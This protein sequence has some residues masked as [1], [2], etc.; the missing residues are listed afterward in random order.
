MRWTALLPGLLVV[1]SLLAPARAIAENTY[2]KSA[3][4][5]V[6]TTASALPAVGDSSVTYRVTTATNGSDCDSV[7]SGSAMADCRW[8]GSGYEPI[9]LAGGGDNL[10]SHIA[11]QILQM[12]AYAITTSSTV[13]GRDLSVDGAKLD[14]IAAGA[15]VGLG[16][17]PSAC[18]G[19]QYVTDQNQSGVLTCSTP[20]GLAANLAAVANGTSLTI[21]SSTGTS[22]SIPA[23][24]TSAWGAMTDEDKTKLDGITA[25]AIADVV[26]DLTPQLGGDLDVQRF[27]ITNLD[28]LGGAWFYAK[29]VTEVNDAIARLPKNYGA[30][31][32][33]GATI[34]LA[35]GLFSGFNDVKIGAPDSG[36]DSHSGVVIRGCGPGGLVAFDGSGAGGSTTLRA[37]TATPM[38]SLY[39]CASCRV[40]NLVM[41]GADVATIGIDWG[42]TGGGFPTTQ[43]TMQDLHIINIDGPGVRVGYNENAIGTLTR[44][45][46]TATA[47][48]T[49]HGLSANERVTIVGA[50]DANFNGT[51][52]TTYVDA[53]TFTY[54]VANT[55]ATSAT[56][57]KFVASQSPKTQVDT[58][59]IKNSL[60]RRVESCYQQLHSQSIGWTME[61]V[62]CQPSATA[63][64]V[65]I[66]LQMGEL[67]YED[68]YFS[69][70]AN[71]QVFV[72]RGPLASR[73]TIRNNQTEW[74][75]TTGGT[76]VDDDDT[77][78]YDSATVWAN[79]IID[80]NAIVYSGAMN[81][82]SVKR[83]GAYTVTNN[84]LFNQGT[85]GACASSS[86]ASDTDSYPQDRLMLTQF[87][88]IDSC[89]VNARYPDTWKPTLAS[90]VI[91]QS[92]VLANDSAPTATG[93]CIP[94]SVWVD[95]NA[96]SGQRLNTCEL[97]VGVPT[98]V[99]QSG[100]GSSDNLGNH[101]AT[102]ALNM[103][104][105]A[106]TN[107]GGLQAAPAP[108]TTTVAS[109]F[110]VSAEDW[111]TWFV[112][113]GQKE[114]TWEDDPNNPHVDPI[115]KTKAYGEE[116]YFINLS[117]TEAW[118]E[119][120]TAIGGGDSDLIG[121]GIDVF[122][123]GGSQASGDE[124]Y[125]GL[126]IFVKDNWVDA[127]GTLGETIAAGAG[128]SEID[129]SDGTISTEESKMLGEGKIIVFGNGTLYS[130]TTPAPG[131]IDG[132]GAVTAGWSSVGGA[133]KG[134]WVLGSSPGIATTGYCLH[135]VAAAY[136]DVNGTVQK[137]WLPIV[138]VSG[139]T[140]TTEWLNQGFDAGVPYGYPAV[141][142]SNQIRIAACAKLGPPVFD[143]GDKIVDRMTITR[144]AGFPGASGAFTV[145]AYP[146]ITGMG[147]Q[148][149][150]ANNMGRMYPWT[151]VKV[152]NLSDGSAMGGQYQIGAAFDPHLLDGSGFIDGN[153]HAFE[154]G[155]RCDQGDCETGLLYRY[156]TPATSDEQAITIAVDETSW[157]TN[158]QTE[159][160]VRIL[161]ENN[162]HDL[163]VS[164]A[165]GWGQNGTPF[166]KTTTAAKTSGN[167]ANW[168]SSGRVV[169]A[170]APCGSG[171][172]GDNLRVEDGDNGGTFTAMADADFE[173]SGDVNFVRTAGTPDQIS[174]LVRSGAVAFSE[175]AGT[176]GD[177]QIAAG[178]VDLNSSEVEGT[179]PATLGGT[180]LVS[181]TAD[182]LLKAEGASAFTVTGISIADSTN[183]LTSP[184]A[185]DFAGAVAA[186]SF[187]ADPPT[188]TNVATLVFK[189]G[190][191][192]AGGT[193]KLTVSGP[194][195][196]FASDRA[197]TLQDDSTPF[198]NCVTPGSLADGDKGDITVSGS[199]ATWNVDADVIASAEIADDGVGIN[200]LD[201]VTGNTPTNG[202]CLTYSTDSGG[203]LKAVA[204]GTGSV[205]ISGTPVAAQVAY[206]TDAS[207][208]AGD[209]GFTYDSA[210]DI[211]TVGSVANPATTG[212][213][214]L[215]NA[216]AI[217][218][219]NDTNTA[220]VTISLDA[221]EVFQVT[222]GTLDAGDLSGTAA[223][224]V[225]AQESVADDAIGIDELDLVTGNTPTNGQCLSYSTDAGGS[226]KA[227][228]CGAGG[229]N[230]SNSGTPVA[231]QVAVWLDATTVLGDAGLTFNPTTNVLTAG[232][233]DSA[234][235]A[236]AGGYVTLTE[237]ADDGT[238]TW[239]LK[240]PDSGL[241]STTTCTLDA[242]G[243]IPA[244][245][246]AVLGAANLGTDSVSADELNATGVEAELE[247][248][249][250][251]T[252]LSDGD[253]ACAALNL[254]RRNAG[255]TAFECVAPSGGGNVSSA[256]T[257]VQFQLAI[258]DSSS[259]ILGDSGIT[260]NT[261]TDTITAATFSGALS[262]NATTATT[263]GAGD[264]AT[265]FFSSGTIEDVIIT[266]SAESDEIDDDVMPFDDADG[267]FTA[268]AIGPALEELNDSIN[269][270]APNGTGAKLHWSQ[271]LG[272]PAGFADGNDEG[273]GGGDAVQFDG[274]DAASPVNFTTNGQTEFILCTGAG[275]PAVGCAAAG[276]VV[277]LN[278]YGYTLTSNSLNTEECVF[279]TDGTGGGGFL[280]EGTGAADAN[281]QRHL[282]AAANGADTTDFI[283][284]ASS[285]V[286]D[287]LSAATAA[288][289]YIASAALNDLGEL[290]TQLGLTNAP[291]DDVV[292]VGDS[293]TAGSWKAL[294]DSD[295]AGQ[296]LVY[297]VTTNAF[298]AGTDDDVPEAADFSN[299]SAVAPISMNPTGTITT[300]M[301]TDRLLGRDTAATGV[302][303]EVAVGGGL[304]F[305]GAPG[306]QRSALT[307]D[308]TASAGSNATTVANVAAGATVSI[309]ETEVQLGATDR[310][311]GRDTAGAG[312]AEEIQ[313]TGGLEFSGAGAI[314]R[315]ALTGD[316]TAT[317]GSGTTVVANVPSGATVSVDETEVQL[318]ATDR[319]VGR[320]TAGA[321]GAEEIAVSGGLE[322]SGAGAI[323]RSALTGDVTASAGSNATA[324]AA[325]AVGI[326]ELDLIDGDTPVNGDCLTYDTG[327][328]GTIE[329]IT[330]PSGGS[331]TVADAA[332]DTTTWP[333]LALDQTG[334]LVAS[335]DAGLSYDASAN[336]L[337]AT[338]GVTAGAPSDPAD[339]GA[340]RLDNAA[341][342]AWEASPA[343]TDVSITVDSAEA[344]VLAGA[345]GLTVPADSISDSELD[346]NA[347][348]DWTGAH[349]FAS[350]VGLG[351][352]ATATTP[353]DT[354]NDTSVATTAMVT[355]VTKS[356]DVPAGAMEVD[357][358][359]CTFSTAGVV[360]SGP[361]LR[362]INCP[363]NASGIV[364]FEL[365]MPDSW[366]AGTITVEASAYTVD[367]S[368]TG[369][370]DDTIGWDVSC[371]ARGD[372]ETINSTWG[373][374]ANLDVTFA[375]QYVE[376]HVTSGAITVNDPEAGDSLYC[377]MVVDTTTTDA[378]TA[379]MRLLG[380]KLEYGTNS[381]SD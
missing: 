278:V 101:T 196:G 57:A 11:S 141:T 380:V 282:F 222:G 353:A 107:V 136:A 317:A 223:A 269:S 348:F 147:V 27:D 131:T 189:E 164:K 200:E 304:E 185:A 345:S 334:T 351:G 195:G 13:D 87:G 312:G 149:L 54:T 6:V 225:V 300:S 104:G 232:G 160:F 138:D 306:I 177:A 79:A 244:S 163:T 309:D 251:L 367:A 303:E 72:K 64:L 167:C 66:D 60:I 332:A 201:L 110:N 266:G 155:L 240:V 260:V 77:S 15:T 319:L 298:S 365:H 113:D 45:G 48:A 322:F 239:T 181:P 50:S 369:G 295:G 363:D 100:G 186:A 118:G 49:G 65:G 224:N 111:E 254:V 211:L 372:G 325:D 258:W 285:A 80:G 129:I 214:R 197:C 124:G 261:T 291:A 121:I 270:G 210:S 379:D 284:T 137:I 366:D 192:E 352:S 24:T 47:V 34:Q 356:V 246:L 327:T 178:A 105:Y 40:E 67:A 337:T 234:A 145:T 36:A 33:T 86:F 324:I 146:G 61:R 349:T 179:L 264:S 39:S 289:T 368:V 329:A 333:V 290:D 81:F 83:E 16:A 150:M 233:Y 198:D 144:A 106:Q 143:A 73:L 288:S 336:V 355:S 294:A 265:A 153:K 273:G 140:I 377:R 318:G 190:A 256:G 287:A 204:C 215:A 364:Y 236:T 165:A 102:Q 213:L 247:A 174:A 208:I 159:D 330:C 268:T 310:L 148:I 93:H 88:N 127:A 103:A 175:L 21:T 32:P 199:G 292:L 162:T 212:A 82:L 217:G 267:L 84:N 9:G 42:D 259:T 98:W 209:A 1:L 29:N 188:G 125:Q 194:T 360:N 156:D 370:A 340:V 172:S 157:T 62:T 321:G 96:T 250:D 373:T 205:S 94:G 296:K 301:A 344:V 235:D 350:T 90:D 123:T 255:D 279:T 203:S 76:F 357:G 161:N 276:D 53:N 302:A 202:Q 4:G 187:D 115:L 35:C 59:S 133:G 128:T 238:N 75:G 381:V 335:S 361:F 358:T 311:V 78:A 281:D 169:D 168:D 89:D 359:N 114:P 85:A 206:W 346:E 130:L 275:T 91:Y 135:S 71:N 19:G 227:I 315:S 341:L 58:G 8:T 14:G 218:W 70:K 338:G 184:G 305:T 326:D 320:D 220:N 193:N 3:G 2:R 182:R 30:S 307:G 245:C 286:T 228:A 63:G 151:G 5:V 119:H 41:D 139:A 134:V 241:S 308:V 176:L 375:T 242:A 31:N 328:G 274:V 262:G 132:N 229:G 95:T 20:P 142:G 38:L 316:V 92:T 112:L 26:Q 23:A 299:L 342:I 17:D 343:G 51:Y 347:P 230:V 237:G 44:S 248:V 68:G 207:T 221:S 231:N 173:D 374:A 55:G 378:T 166:A 283:A 10:G 12:G 43:A 339:A 170:G 243:T 252:S 109:P 249:L 253:N 154:Y 293:A 171:G 120:S 331:V 99:A 216:G 37:T 74:H 25:L 56:G 263:A 69:A 323:Q 46:T 180:G 376:E 219:R 297:D 52:I 257:P 22:A 280:C 158:A 116:R 362:P 371:M 28:Q 183:D 126:R 122:G 152:T 354:D 314:Q 191:G 313:V 97:V 18:P 277:A 226:L 117:E 272:V 271:L 108:I 7:D